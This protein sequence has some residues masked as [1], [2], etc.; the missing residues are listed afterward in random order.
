M[1]RLAALKKWK[2]VTGYLKHGCLYSTI[3]FFTVSFTPLLF[4][5]F[6]K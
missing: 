2:Q 5:I 4:I 3:I 6:K 1:Q